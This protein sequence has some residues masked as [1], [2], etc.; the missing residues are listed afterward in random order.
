MGILTIRKTILSLILG[1]DI[2]DANMIAT[3]IKL[4]N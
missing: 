1:L 3:L 4:H 2:S